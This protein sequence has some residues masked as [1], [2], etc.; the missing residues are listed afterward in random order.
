MGTN[1]ASSTDNLAEGCENPKC[2]KQK[3]KTIKCCQQIQN[4]NYQLQHEKEEVEE[5]LTQEY[6]ENQQLS[7]QLNKIIKDKTISDKELSDLKQ[8]YET[9]INKL[10]KYNTRNI[11]KKIQRRDTKLETINKTLTNEKEKSSFMEESITQSEKEILVLKEDKR[12]LQK[13]ISYLKSKPELF[14]NKQNENISKL[15]D[16]N[17]ELQESNAILQEIIEECTKI[18]IFKTRKDGSR[19]FC[20]EMKKTYMELIS[21]GVSCNMCSNVI[22]SVIKNMTG[23]ELNDMPEVTFAKRMA[24]QANL[25]AKFQL[26][27]T[28]LS[29]DS[30]NTLQFDG[31]S[32][33]G[34]HFFTF[35]ITTSEKTYS[36]SLMDLAT[37]NSA[38]QLNATKALFNELGEIYV[39]LTNEKNPEI[40]TKVIS[41]M[42]KTIHNT[43]SDR[44]PT[45]KPYVK[46][47][48]EWRKSLLPKALENWETL[49]EECQ[50]S[51]I[52]I[53][54]FYCGLHLLTNFAD[55]SNKSLKKFEEIS[56]AEKIGMK[57]LSQFSNWGTR[58]ESAAQRLIRSCCNLLQIHGCE[59]AGRPQQFNAYLFENGLKNYLVPFRGNRFNILFQN[60][61]AVYG[62]LTHIQDFIEM[63]G[64]GNNLLLSVNADIES[65]I[66]LAG[67]RALG[68]VD[69]HINRPLWKLLDCNDVS[70]TD[71]SQYYQKLH[72]SISNL[73]QDSSPM[74]DENYQMFENYPPEKDL[75][76]FFALHAVEE[77][78]E[79]LDVLTTQAL[80]L[81]LAS[82]LSVIKRQLVDHLTGGK[83]S[84]PNED[85]MLISQSVPKTNQSNESN[86]G[87]LDRIKR[88]KP[89]ATTAH[90]EG[91]V[92]YVNNKTSDWLD[93]QCNEADI[94]QKVSKLLPKF[95]EKWRQRSKDIKK[96][97]IEMLQIRADEIKRKK[98]K[99]IAEKQ[100]IIDNILRYGQCKTE[101]DVKKLLSKFKTS[102]MKLVAL[103]FQLKYYK[104]VLSFE[105]NNAFY[106]FFI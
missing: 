97:R 62:H 35:D 16:E 18:P 53:H 56:T 96:K 77:N 5:E 45:N 8:K 58:S 20:D 17:K 74:F 78:N 57:T 92:L 44:G 31:T 42:V 68:L 1:K 67:V 64:T 41:K 15:R 66:A 83:H 87:Q 49:N 2:S 55:Y 101:G 70:I 24:L 81:I 105:G 91:M 21:L 69:V 37:E 40:L 100:K 51:I 32:K 86:F 26:A 22:K 27:D 90:I 98:M 12:N 82:I 103:K 9:V 72:D 10:Q 85:L 71:M 63:Y 29:K 106:K 54:D 84:D 73:V 50:Q 76:G 75:F 36:A 11:N 104:C 65:K 52:D 48:E 25:M 46:L 80:E 33:W 89:N 3:L 59:T 47:F 88:F 99:K 19:E 34:E 60:A 102:H 23:Q 7:D 61:R 43:M 79:E 13:R 94:M 93:T 14:E 30:A 28:I 6:K 39:S 4:L 95:I 38:T